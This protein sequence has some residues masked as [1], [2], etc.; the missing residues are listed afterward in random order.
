M[1]CIPSSSNVAA[2]LLSSSWFSHKIRPNIQCA[3]GSALRALRLGLL[4]QRD[5]NAPRTANL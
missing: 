3:A 2:G 4:P 1:L 5:P